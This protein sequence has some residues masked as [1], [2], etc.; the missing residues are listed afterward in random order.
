MALYKVS[1]GNTPLASD[2]NQYYDAFIGG[3]HDIGQ[4]T[5]AP[6]VAAPA[7]ITTGTVVAG[8]ALGIGAYQYVV[9]FVTGY[10]KTNGT[11]VITGETTPSPALSVTTTSGNQAV[12]LSGIP[13]GGSTVIARNIYRTAVGGSVFKLLTQIPNNTAT[14]YSDTTADASLGTANPPTVNTTG[15]SL[16]AF[17]V[18]GV[19]SM[20]PQGTATST[21]TSYNSNGLQFQV[22]QWVSNAATTQSVKMD[23]ESLTST[24]TR[25]KLWDMYN[26]RPWVRFSQGLI[27]LN[28]STS[29]TSG[30]YVNLLKINNTGGSF[31]LQDST[32]TTWLNVDNKAN[33]DFSYN[34]YQIQTADYTRRTLVHVY[35]SAGGDQTLAGGGANAV[36]QYDAKMIDTQGEWDS[37]NFWWV[38][39]YTGAYQVNAAIRV[40]NLNTSSYVQLYVKHITSGNSYLI[41][42]N[43]SATGTFDMAGSICLQ[44][45]AGDKVQVTVTAGQSCNINASK[46][47]SFLNIVQV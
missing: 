10:V 12:N 3:N 43:P 11:L 37:V 40:I 20:L 39:G 28:D 41:A 36:M 2:V 35:K 22:S 19:Q 30:S 32:G 44:I 17:N 16:G 33:G 4:I 46:L 8:T 34:G 9:T 25:V 42:Q 31:K 24:T 14:T 5:F 7:A 1:V 6:S 26:N 27:E 18:S 29:T 23:A 21:T 45:V 38:A 13:V 47:Y 15:T